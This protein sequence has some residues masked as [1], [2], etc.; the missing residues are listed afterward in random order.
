MGSRSRV[1]ILLLAAALPMD[2]GD[3]TISVN[4]VRFVRPGSQ[5][6]ERC[7]TESPIRACTYFFARQLLGD[8]AL[9]GTS[10]VVV[11]HARFGVKTFLAHSSALAHERIHIRDV[12]KDVSEYV[13]GLRMWRFDSQLDCAAAFKQAADAFPATM[14]AIQWKSNS[15]RHP[16]LPTPEALA[17]RSAQ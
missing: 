14:D 9:S 8:C 5:I 10:W 4:S 13:A 15:T 17:A 7:A 3:L 12:E 16:Q 1:G 6:V 2:G 11:P